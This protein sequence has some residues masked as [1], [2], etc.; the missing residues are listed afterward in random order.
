MPEVVELE[1]WAGVRAALL[2]DAG[3]AALVGARV[4]DEPGPDIGL[5]YIRLRSVEPVP[6]DTD[7]AAGYV[8]TMGLEV[9]SRPDIR[10]KTE[11]TRITGAIRNALHRRPDLVPVVGFGLWEI[12]FLTALVERARDGATYEGRVAL[13]LR[14]DA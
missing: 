1:A 4:V 11:A 6:D 12:E 14:L 13:E 7:G 3:V 2:A 10:G 9:H 5:P 8:L